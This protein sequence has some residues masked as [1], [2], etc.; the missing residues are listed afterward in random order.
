MHPRPQ[1]A[2]THPITPY[3]R[4]IPLRLADSSRL[5][6]ELLGS[7]L[8]RHGFAPK[9]TIKTG[10][11]SLNV[12]TQGLASLKGQFKMPVITVTAV[13]V[14]HAMLAVLSVTVV[15]QEL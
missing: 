14:V 13:T 6:L 4:P 8:Q 10:N 5:F 7:R 1:R 3:H 12:L 2:P 9:E 15:T 11:D